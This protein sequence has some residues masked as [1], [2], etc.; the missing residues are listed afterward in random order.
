MPFCRY[1]ARLQ[2]MKWSLDMD[3]V[4]LYANSCVR[5]VKYF[6]LNAEGN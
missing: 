4:S 5:K 2:A 1:I 3:I 6:A